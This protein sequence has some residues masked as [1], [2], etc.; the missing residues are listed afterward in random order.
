MGV[1]ELTAIDHF[2][3]ELSG[4]FDEKFSTTSPGAGTLDY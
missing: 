4:L 2:G 3:C 1:G